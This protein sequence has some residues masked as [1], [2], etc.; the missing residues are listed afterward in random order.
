M[1]NITVDN[2]Y[3]SQLVNLG[4]I[5][6]LKPLICNEVIEVSFQTMWLLA[7]LIGDNVK[8]LQIIE[9]EKIYKDILRVGVSFDDN[10][11]K[12]DNDNAN[13]QLLC[14]TIANNDIQAFTFALSNLVRSFENKFIKYKIESLKAIIVLITKFYMNFDIDNEKHMTQITDCLWVLSYITENYHKTL[15]FLVALNVISQIHNDI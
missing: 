6:K 10:Y 13:I 14:F 2:N 4:I 1:T 9:K 3:C 5:E 12:C 7:N 8:N 11:L 15:D